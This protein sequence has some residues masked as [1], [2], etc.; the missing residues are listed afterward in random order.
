MGTIVEIRYLRIYAMRSQAS[1]NQMTSQTEELQTT[2]YLRAQALSRLSSR[3]LWTWDRLFSISTWLRIYN[4][5]HI[6]HLAKPKLLSSFK[7]RSWGHSLTQM[8]YRNQAPEESTTKPI[9]SMKAKR[10]SQIKHHKAK[11]K[12][13]VW[14]EP[15]LFQACRAQS[16]QEA[17]NNQDNWAHSANEPTVAPMKPSNISTSP[18]SLPLE[19]VSLPN[20]ALQ[21][22]QCSIINRPLNSSKTL[23]SHFN[24]T[25]ASSR[26]TRLPKTSWRRSSRL[27]TASI[28]PR[29]QIVTKKST[30]V[31]C[32]TAKA[33]QGS[34][35]VLKW[36]I[37][38]LP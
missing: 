27:W 5:K 3:T 22:H 35:R 8:G 36:S 23:A 6:S 30:V 1:N 21:A 33:A 28:W 19:V 7:C 20:K 31:T 37:T 34:T 10:H 29:P 17:S 14:S 4:V 32:I 13:R 25:T 11:D 18:P 2:R 26:A 16:T 9:C 38:V 24:I 15:V 12:A